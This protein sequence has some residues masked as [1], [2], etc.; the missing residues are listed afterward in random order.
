MATEH[1]G[2]WKLGGLLTTPAAIGLAI[3]FF[4]PWVK[5]Q[6]SPA[7]APDD[8][9]PSPQQVGQM[10]AQAPEGLISDDGAINLGQASGYELAMGRLSPPDIKDPEGKVK[11]KGPNEGD[12][13]PRYVF[14]AGIALPVLLLLGGLNVITGKTSPRTWAVLALIFAAAGVGLCYQA[15]QV[16]YGED[17]AAAQKKNA[18]RQISPRAQEIQSN[19][20]EAMD[21]MLQTVPTDFLKATAIVYG[22]VGLICLPGLFA[23]GQRRQVGPQT[24]R[25][26]DPDNKPKPLQQP[27]DQQQPLHQQQTPH[28]PPVAPSPPPA[29][30]DDADDDNKPATGGGLFQGPR[31]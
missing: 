15:T 5:L 26:Y 18:G 12:I 14:W 10:Q 24:T 8:E 25:L 9:K 1:K 2:G 31:D 22:A 11:Q 29:A 13:R 7:E 3:L 19:M 28:V 21:K 30:K 16:N 23:A 4:M 17:M 6:C 20:A 27:A